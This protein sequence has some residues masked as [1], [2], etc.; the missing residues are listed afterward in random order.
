MTR[1]RLP[2]RRP[3][4]TFRL[5]HTWLK[6]TDRAMT[7]TMTVTV[8]RYGLDD[9]RIGEVFVNCDNHLNERAIALWHDIGIL[10]SFALQHG[11]TVGEL[12]AAMAR[13]EVR[14]AAVAASLDWRTPEGSPP[15]SVLGRISIAPLGEPVWATIRLEEA[16]VCLCKD[17]VVG[18]KLSA[19]APPV[20]GDYG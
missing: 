11:A 20:A 16:I 18:L 15:A 17:A 8:G 14:A 4:E 5:D 1:E 13:G 10:I 2:D 9:R 19:V 3:M 7:E 6:G 12:C